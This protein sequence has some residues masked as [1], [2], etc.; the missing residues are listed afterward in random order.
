MRDGGKLPYWPAMMLRATAMA[1]C[2]MGETAFLREVAVGVFP[3][4]VKVGNKSY[5]SRAEL[6]KAI[7]GLFGNHEIEPYDWRRDSPLYKDDP[8]YHPELRKRK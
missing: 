7:D 4:P 3:Q 8:R 5:W 2:D 6:D 1:Y